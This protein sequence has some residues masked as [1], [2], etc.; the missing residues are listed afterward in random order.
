MKKQILLV[1]CAVTLCLHVTAQNKSYS[2]QV[3]DEDGTPVAG[4]YILAESLTGQKSGA[5]TDKD[6]FYTIGGVDFTQGTITASCLGL[7]TV[8]V[9]LAPNATITMRTNSNMLDESLVV[10]YE[11]VKKASYSG[12]AQMVRQEQIE[13]LPITSIEN[14]ITG[15]VSGVQVTS[16][17]GQTGSVSSIRIR[18]NGSMN[19]GNEP[20]YVVDGVPVL[21]GNVGQ[22]DNTLVNTTNNVIASLNVEDIE[23]VSILK[24]AAASSLFGSRAANGVVLITTKQ[25]KKGRAVVEFK[26]SLG[27]TPRWATDNYE[28]ASVQE[29][30]NMLYQVFYDYAFG[31]TRTFGGKTYFGGSEEGATA[32]ALAQLN[33]RF[34]RHGYSFTTNDAGRY[35]SVKIG[36]Y[37]NSGRGEGKYFDW[38]KALFRTAVYNNYDIAASGG[39]EKVNYYTSISYTKE[40][41]R[42][43]I[44]T[45]DRFSA[46]INVSSKVTNWLEM[47]T[48]AYISQTRKSGFNDSR[49]TSSNGYMSVKNLLWG[50]YW[51]TDYTTG[52]D[53]KTRY[54]S[55]AR[56]YLWQDTQ[57]ENQSRNT[58]V[59]AIESLIFHI[60]PGLDIT[61]KCSFDETY[62]K[63]HVYYSAEHPYASSDNGLVREGRTVYDKYVFS[64]TGTYRNSW[65][66]NNLSILAGGEIENNTTNYTLIQ[67]S[68]LPTTTLHTVSTAG[69]FTG[70]GH[71]WGYSIASYLSKIDYNYAEK[72]Y[73]SASLRLDGSS[74]L[75]PDERWG[76]FWSVGA[77]WRINKEPFMQNISWLDELKLRLTV[78]TSGT[79]PTS[80]YGYMNLMS[81]TSAYVGSPGGLISSI[82]ND[83]LTWETS[84]TNNIGIDFAVLK[85][86]IYGTI[87]IYNKDSK[88]LLQDVPISTTTGQ[89]SILMNIGGIN[90]HGV[91]VELGASLI[92][93][94]KI[95][96]SANFNAAFLS[97]KVTKLYNGAD[98]IWYDP[99][100]KNERAQFIYREGESTLAF[101]GYEWAGVDSSNGKS[102]Y[103]VNGDGSESGE[104]YFT[105]KGRTA[106]YDFNKANYTIIGNAHPFM[107]GGFSTNL[108][109]NNFDVEA[110]FIYKLGGNIYDGA[111]CDVVDD[112]FYFERIR[113]KIYY[114]NMWTENNTD[115]TLPALSGYDLLDA[116]QY[117]SRHVYSATFLRLKNFVVGYTLPKEL[118]SKIHLSNARVYFNGGNLLTLAKYKMAD[119]EVNAYGTRGWEVPYGMSFTIGVDVKF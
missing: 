38:D 82:G 68:N 107:S 50:L 72:Y 52:E 70:S 19:A 90:N 75:S 88:N 37:D 110:D 35:Q 11:T 76:D 56:N 57:W 97:S 43:K 23:S 58:R 112:G 96:W 92:K 48:N 31:N 113:S 46:R 106:T 1:L 117:C 93:N 77:S 17:T 20:L 14:A 53:W 86:R 15:R 80:N 55:Y 65:G 67:G 61:S 94:R 115:G 51:P 89:N 45:F 29:N 26:A 85:N 99:T 104:D 64:T 105:Y 114:D 2:G 18:G 109:W 81:Y 10:A 5:I 30:V 9:S 22:M 7:E 84:V 63:D 102:I 101:Y 91:E 40:D 34:N 95:D 119:P 79:T 25:G 108:R 103:Y 3:L 8:T 78:G 59:S 73:A 62:V 49:D 44:N 47:G 16:G 33:D 13:N 6:G 41:C 118:A 21:S 27:I 24:D 60:I 4:A 36:E 98:I 54:G 12:S 32:Y 66:K 39:G 100:G 71:E 74:R 42:L 69:T 87:E 83:D 116:R 111:E 28:P